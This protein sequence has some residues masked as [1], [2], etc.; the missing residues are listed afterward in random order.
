MRNP[1]YDFEIANALLE[2][3]K[4]Q[5]PA[6]YEVFLDDTGLSVYPNHDDKKLRY[7]YGFVELKAE[8]FD[9]RCHT[10]RNSLDYKCRAR[11]YSYFEP[12]SFESAFAFLQSHF[13]EH[14]NIN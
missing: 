12:D 10:H 6:T 5:F 14:S 9:V 11:T 13:T 8:M 7:V 4:S 3:F 1:P 2:Y